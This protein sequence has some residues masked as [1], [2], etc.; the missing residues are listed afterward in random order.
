MRATSFATSLL[1][2]AC[3]AAGAAHSQQNDDNVIRIAIL[4]FGTV[5]WE[6]DVIQRHD[7]DDKHGFS[8]DI[9][10]LAGNQATTV[11]LQAGD[12][13]MIVSDWLW[14]SRQRA[15]GRDFTFVPFSSAVGAIM[16][17]DDSDI[18]T[19]EDLQGIKL[20]VAGSP[21]DKGWLLL[22][23]FSTERYGFDLEHGNEVLFGAA[24][25]L[26]E[27]ALRGEVDAVLNYWH[28][29]ARL[30][31][32]GFR[33]IIDSNEGAMALG[34][35]GPIS[36]VG[37]VFDEGWAEDNIDAVQG[38]FRASKEAKEIMNTSDEEWETLRDMTNAEDDATL[39]AL[40]DRFRE[41]IPSRPLSEELEDT[42]RI[43]DLLAEIGGEALVGPATTMTPGTFWPV[44]VEGF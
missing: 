35:E 44:M 27:M 33:R 15:D 29:S 42:A 18:H 30:E 23:G 43:Y 10:P 21:L 12:V 25:L 7:L 14:A 31:P 13:D 37:Y 39:E 36:A 20:A 38:F 34:A 40:R 4:Q 16:V 28:F 3:L 26:T 9:V 11:A 41:G 22:R 6:L 5:N 2:A 24:P 1:V 19:V 17:P 32:Q 8:L